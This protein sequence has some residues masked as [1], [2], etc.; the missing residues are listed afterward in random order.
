MRIGNFYIPKYI[1][2]ENSIISLEDHR[3]KL[4]HQSSKYTSKFEEDINI[5]KNKCDIK[6]NYE[7]NYE[8]EFPIFIQNK[9]LWESLKKKYN[10][11]KN[12][13]NTNYFV[14]DYL[15]YNLNI[16]IEIDSDLHFNNYDNAR[17]EYI[18]REYGIKTYRM[19]NY[20]VNKINDLKKLKSIL[21]QRECF[22]LGRNIYSKLHIINY[23]DI[24]TNLFQYVYSKSIN[25]IELILD[26]Y[27][28]TGNNLL[29]KDIN[30]VTYNINYFKGL[31][32]DEIGCIRIMLYWIFGINL[33]IIN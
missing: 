21:N 25:K 2:I 28:N 17:D 18:S 4:I 31:N 27:Y 24:I 15:F 8:K 32:N 22:K 5:L 29:S 9:N 20:G 3:N 19:F 14:V 11:E 16:I 23:D 30:C 26:N 12:R 10:V 13:A 33:N 1:V 7:L 6:F